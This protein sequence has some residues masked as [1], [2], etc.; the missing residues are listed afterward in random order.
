MTSMSYCRHENTVIELEQVW[1]LWEEWTLEGSNEYEARARKRLIR[2]VQEMHEQ[3]E[4]DGTYDEIG[5][6]A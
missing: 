2:L 5:G 3:F 1:D 6:A 4:M